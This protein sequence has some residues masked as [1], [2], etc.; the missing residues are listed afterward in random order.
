[1]AGTVP[2][3]LGWQREW[4]WSV[5]QN[6]KKL[7]IGKPSG[8]E[9]TPV[10]GD[11][12]R[13]CLRERVKTRPDICS[14]DDCPPRRSFDAAITVYLSVR[15][16]EF[17]LLRDIEKR[18]Q[19]LGRSLEGCWGPALRPPRFIDL[20]HQQVLPDVLAGFERTEA[21]VAAEGS[22]CAAGSPA[23]LGS[24]NLSMTSRFL[25]S[26]NSST[27]SRRPNWTGKKCAKP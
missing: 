14:I 19:I 2:A 9:L 8:S 17:G 7:R 25:E 22:H 21:G 13:I 18:T 16:S 23:Q 3:A 27:L 6:R 24:E 4:G 11:H 10:V 12:G 15:D 1:M 20:G 5:R 26:P